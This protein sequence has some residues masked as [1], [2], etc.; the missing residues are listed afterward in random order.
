MNDTTKHLVLAF[1]GISFKISDLFSKEKNNIDSCI[2]S[3]L[4]NHELPYQCVLAYQ[5]TQEAVNL[6]K[7]GSL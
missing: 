3:L 2:K 6:S 4:G 7:P 1:K 5:A